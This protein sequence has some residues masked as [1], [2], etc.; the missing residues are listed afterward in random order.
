MWNSSINVMLFD[1]F[2]G[3]F[4]ISAQKGF[5]FDRF[6]KV[7]SIGFPHVRFIYKRNVFLIIFEAILRF[8]LGK[9]SFSTGFIWVSATRFCLL[10]NIVFHWFYK[11]FRHGGMSCGTHL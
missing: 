7:L 10:R 11:A 8:W 5:I 3:H 4:A 9:S 6:Y 1:H 2:Q